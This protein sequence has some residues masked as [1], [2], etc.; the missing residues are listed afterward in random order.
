MAWKSA[1]LAE[2]ISFD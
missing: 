1:G 2:R